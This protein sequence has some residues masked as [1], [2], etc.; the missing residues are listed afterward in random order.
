MHAF[1]RSALFP[2]AAAC[3]LLLSGC[4][5]L[6]TTENGDPYTPD[7]VVSMTEKEFAVLHPDIVIVSAE[8]EKE[9]PFQRNT[10]VL[11]DKAY[12]ITFSCMSNVKLPTLPFPGGQRDTD[13]LFR[14]AE[15]YSHYINAQII[16]G[17]AA[18]DIHIATEA[19]VRE[20]ESSKL[21]RTV[22]QGDKIPLFEANHYV[23]VNADTKGEDLADLCREIYQYYRPEKSD[24]LLNTLGIRDIA[25]YYLPSGQADL[26]KG[27][28]LT[29]FRINEEGHKEW[30][31]V[32]KDNVNGPPDIT[33]AGTLERELADRF[34]RLIR[35]AAG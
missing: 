13:A 11:C 15:A 4:S 7:E 17:A 33:E 32:L 28:Y 12:E 2:L 22:G 30:A 1:L 3:V 19:E 24:A 10:Y 23:F 21:T 8:T 27:V 34:Q 18:R 31:R 9:K 6:L 29:T 16:P 25:F 20:L 5:F 35:D 26:K 14:Y